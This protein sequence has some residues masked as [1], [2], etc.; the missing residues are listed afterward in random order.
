MFTVTITS[1]LR[2]CLLAWTPG[3]PAVECS[4]L[5]DISA[6]VAPKLSLQKLLMGGGLLSIPVRCRTQLFSTFPSASGEGVLTLES[7]GTRLSLECPSCGRAVVRQR[8]SR[9]RAA[10]DPPR[11]MGGAVLPGFPLPRPA[12]W[13][14]RSARVTVAPT[15]LPEGGL[16][17]V[18]AWG[19]P[20][21]WARPWLRPSRTTWMVYSGNAAEKFV[22]QPSI[23]PEVTF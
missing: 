14:P 15:R 17:V 12:R 23:A 3:P 9:S 5:E 18:L 22:W 6:A 13:R 1:H 19:C 10:T 16:R 7:A 2:F 8:A 20:L 4:G 21:C 11:A